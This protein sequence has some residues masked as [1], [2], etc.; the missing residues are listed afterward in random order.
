[1]AFPRILILR[2]FAK[3]GFIASIPTPV[4]VLAFGGLLAPLLLPLLLLNVLAHAGR[5]IREDP[6]GGK[7]LRHNTGCDVDDHIFVVVDLLASW[8]RLEFVQENIIQCLVV[9][10]C[11]KLLLFLWDNIQINGLEEEELSDGVSRPS[12]SFHK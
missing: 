6:E 10:R 2:L 11:T 5:I 7:V 12:R 8:K 1:M 3:V 4:S 9:A